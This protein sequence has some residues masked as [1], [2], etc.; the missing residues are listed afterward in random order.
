MELHA[1]RLPLQYDQINL[2]R[3]LMCFHRGDLKIFETYLSS[4]FRILLDSLNSNNMRFQIARHTNHPV[5]TF[6][7]LI[8]DGKLRI[9]QQIAKLT[10]KLYCFVEL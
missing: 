2:A 10:K 7:N 1:Y 6:C 3:D 8:E 4:N 5:E 9:Q